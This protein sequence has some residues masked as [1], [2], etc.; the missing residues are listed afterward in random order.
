MQN[1]LTLGE[2]E[3]SNFDVFA[4]ANLAYQ[5][6]HL[7]LGARL[8]NH[9]K[10]DN[11]FVYSVNPFIL[12]DLDDK[13]LKIGYSYATAFIAPT[14]YQSYGSL[15]YVLPNFDLKPETNAS[16]ELDFSFG[17]KDRTFVVNASVFSRKEKDVFVY[18][19]VDFNTYAGK[20]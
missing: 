15:P 12:T 1:V 18:N 17:K 7:D 6:F 10:Y 14:L 13:F 5:I 11:H 16:H 8:N 2:T 19:I 9:S 20:F 4:N 3:I